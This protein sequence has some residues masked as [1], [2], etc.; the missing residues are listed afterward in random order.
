MDYPSENR[1][2]K[3]EQKGYKKPS[4]EQKSILISLNPDVQIC[5]VTGIETQT[6]QTRQ[7]ELSEKKVNAPCQPLSIVSGVLLPGPAESH[8]HVRGWEVLVPSREDFRPISS[9][10]E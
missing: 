3:P 10:T 5:C 8:R 6:D 7:R 9:P 2:N 4:K 1:G